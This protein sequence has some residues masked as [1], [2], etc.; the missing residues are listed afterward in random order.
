MIFVTCTVPRATLTG[1]GRPLAVALLVGVLTLAALCVPTAAFA[2][3]Y[4]WSMPSDFTATPPG[5]NPDHDRYGT[6]SWSYAQGP[7]GTLQF[8]SGFD[9]GLAG[10]SDDPSNP[11]AFVAVNPTDST[12]AGIGPG[13]FAMQ[14]AEQGSIA[15]AW[16]SPVAGTASV[17]GSIIQV[18]PSDASCGFSWS[19]SSSGTTFASGSGGGILPP[20]PVTVAQ[21]ATIYL[22]IQDTST[23]YRASC[24]TA[25]V[26]AAV[27]MP[28]T[29]PTLALWNP[30]TVIRG[31]QPVFSG[32]AS[33]GFGIWG[34]ITVRVYRSSAAGHVLAQTV[35]AG[36]VNGGYSVQASPRLPNGAYTAQAEQDDAAG[37]RAFSGIV[38]FTLDN[39]TPRV[40]LRSLGRKPLLLARPTFAGTAGTGPGTSNVIYIG[41][42]PGARVSATPVR[43]LLTRRSARGL[44]SLT[45]AQGLG[46]PDGA[47]T[48]VAAQVGPGSS[49]VSSPQR[50]Q[51][52]LHSP[53]VTIDSPAIG[54]L[55]TNPK[56]V[57]SGQA[58][59]VAGDFPAV[60]LAVYRGA[61]PI[62]RPLFTARVIRRRAVWSVTSPRTL[63][64]GLYTA[65]ARQSDDAGHSGIAAAHI[66]FVPPPPR[67]IGFIVNLD[68]QG[69]ASVEVTCTTAGGTCS[70]DVLALTQGA[71]QPV[72]GG[73]QGPLRVLFAH[74][75]IPAGQA[76][77]VRQKLPSQVFQALRRA[78]AVG[79]LVSASLSASGYPPIR[80]S[81]PR[82]LVV[83]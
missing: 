3:T 43:Q 37:D 46:L 79:L 20:T 6:T 65:V 49:G 52:K 30:G 18:N 24:V 5:S 48:A 76:V 36:R 68:R 26:T 38:A 81:V 47:Y 56:P 40:T 29:P 82:L 78:R 75:S 2:G 72:P 7:S 31:R 33:S 16:T 66:F 28:S 83:S 21:G 74:V 23:S 70:G 1:V 17:S 69:Y 8:S 13:Q 11:Q 25:A 19:L 34:L 14:P 50:F 27:T 58:G 60:T 15:L 35:I 71:F 54:A 39:T 42:Y 77:L 67:V 61:L 51:V 4:T 45:V 64:V 80:I 59:A 55:V 73:P 41:I 9:G 22:V 12:V 10:W 32:I 44:F 62:G 57:F 63:A 53:A